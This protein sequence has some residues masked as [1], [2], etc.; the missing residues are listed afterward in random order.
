[1]PTLVIANDF[2]MIEAPD[3]FSLSHFL[4]LWQAYDPAV[5]SDLY[6]SAV[7]SRGGL[8]LIDPIPLAAAPLAEL[9]AAGNVAAV[10]VTNSNHCRAA[11]RFARDLGVAILADE[12][13]L[14]ELGDAVTQPVAGGEIVPGLAAIPIAGAASG[15]L[16]FHFTDDGG[17]LVVGDAL[18]H[19]ESHG[20]T[21]LP[22]KYCSNQKE[23][24]GS[25]RR[26]LDWPFERLFFAHG[27]PILSA[28]RARL[29]ALL[30]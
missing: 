30:R 10:L 28:A 23:M 15:E 2:A 11:A 5:K 22:A 24:R 7:Q 17:T 12:S 25:L 20:F 6:S 1:M 16:A 27:A 18:I 21:L 29:E 3:L 8:F 4:W 26:L 13:V 19:V 14:G 9:T